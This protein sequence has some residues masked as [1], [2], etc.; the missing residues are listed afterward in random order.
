M[1]VKK[2]SFYCVL[3]LGMLLTGLSA[4]IYGQGSN[5]YET[6][7]QYIANLQKNPNDN[8]LREEIIRLVLTFDHPP[9]V[10][11]EAEKFMARG[12]ASME[13]AKGP[14]DFKDAVVELE[15]AA[16]AAPW[17]GNIY[18]NLGIVQDKAGDY[19]AAIRD[20]KL[21]LLATPGA[22]DAKAVEMLIYKIEFK[23]EKAD[24]ES[25]ANEKLLKS[26]RED[27]TGFITAALDHGAD[28][29]AR[30][31]NGRTALMIAAINGHLDVVRLLIGR[32]ADINA[33]D[34]SSAAALAYSVNAWGASNP[35]VVLFLIDSG[36]D[37][38]ARDKNGD[39]ALKEVGPYVET[40]NAND[41][42][43]KRNEIRRILEK[44]GAKE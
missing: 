20:L 7:D 43:K 39:T 8:A 23:Q 18:Y 15:K 22:S 11:Q 40:W 3:L 44:A 19:P 29:N 35:E 24:N 27:K 6:L 2:K 9:A 10:P 31:E 36:A 26:A 1:D 37:I 25:A 30:D 41:A 17:L 21:Y 38:N 14:G 13:S 42:D 5:Q 16:L 34:N 33:K 12:Q 28:V 32:G 4:M